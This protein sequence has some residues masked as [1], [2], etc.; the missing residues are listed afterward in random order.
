[1]DEKCDKLLN[2]ILDEADKMLSYSKRAYADG[3][4]LTPDYVAR[5]KQLSDIVLNVYFATNSNYCEVKVSKEES[6]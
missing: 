2:D 3:H 1:M 6:V 5:L 4:V